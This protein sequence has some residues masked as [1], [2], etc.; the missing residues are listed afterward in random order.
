MKN[1]V[2]YTVVFKKCF[3]LSEGHSMHC[4]SEHTKQLSDQRW[5]CNTAILQFTEKTE[6]STVEEV[7]GNIHLQQNRSNLNPYL[8]AFLLVAKQTMKE[9]RGYN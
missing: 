6:S 4:Q 3:F 1:C 5:G 8:F 7:A 2:E 9:P